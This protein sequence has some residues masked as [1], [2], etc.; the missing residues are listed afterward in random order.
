MNNFLAG[1]GYPESRILRRENDLRVE[2][3]LRAAHTFGPE[4]HTVG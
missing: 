3:Y 1:K 4:P 2:N